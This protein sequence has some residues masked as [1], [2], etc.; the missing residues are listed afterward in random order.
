MAIEPA[1]SQMRPEPSARERGLT[2]RSVVLGVLIICAVNVWIA[3]SEYI[4]HASRMNLSHFPLALLVAFLITL[5]PLNWGLKLI[6]PRAG[7]S[8]SELMAVLAMGLVGAAVPAS[9]LTGF[10]LGVIATPFYYASPEN[11]WAL[12]MHEHIPGWIAPSAE[13]NAMRWFFDGLPP[14]T[15]M[16]WEVWVV[17]LFWWLLFIGVVFFVS[18]CLAVIL[19]RQWSVHERL[20]YPLAT[21]AA[22]ISEGSDRWRVLPTFMK[23][24]LF[25]YGFALSFGLLAWNMVTYFVPNM[26]AVPIRGR[27]FSF[28]RDFPTMHIRVNFLTIG[29]AYFANPE[30]LSSIWIFFIVFVVQ[31]GIC[32]RVGFTIGRIEDQWSNYD[33]A[34]SWQNFGAF[35]FFVL[36]G[37]W[38]ARKH[39]AQVLLK[40]VRGDPDVDDTDEMLSYRTAVFG[41]LFG[42]VFILC[43]LRSAGMEF[44]LSS[45]WLVATLVTFI[46][47]ARI[48]AESGLI[49]VRAPLSAQS[50]GSYILGS[51]VLTPASLT[52][53]AFTYTLIANGRALFMTGLV[54]AARIGQMLKANKRRLALAVCVGVLVGTLVSVAITIYLG[55]EHG[56]ANFRDV[57]FS[58]LCRSIF[59]DTVKKMKNPFSASWERIGFLGIGFVVMGI[60]TVMRH[61]FAWWPLHPIGFAI[62]CTYLVRRSVFSIFIAWA[63]KTV[64]LQVGGVGLYRRSKPFFL[65][66]LT[67]YAMG[68]AASFAVDA[69]WFCGMGHGIHSW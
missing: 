55:Y 12:Y 39:L 68:V 28:G 16:P 38:I 45:L 51:D 63:C 1:L 40:A 4:V 65:G 25:W 37:L 53:L 10:F 47:V 20:V 6:S 48:V 18:L 2:A 35:L 41:L 61:A 31:A 67:G 60:L 66:L 36:W 23:S 49:Y 50:F 19:R 5:V 34:N 17:P 52:T 22:E 33:A 58:G 46:G 64:I 24:R 14:G 21:V 44:R 59:Q 26:P 3:Y 13:A 11:Q 29:F 15:R 42:I 9:G 43:W 8:P 54:H 56:A 7:F 57:P 69:I 27:W 30:V 62:S 32:N